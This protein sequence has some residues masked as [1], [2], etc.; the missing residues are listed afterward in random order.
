[1][2]GG[3]G[4]TTTSGVFTTAGNDAIVDWVLVEL[5]S[6]ADP[7]VIVATRAGLL[8]RDGD[9]VDVDGSSSLSFPLPNGNYQVAVRHRNHFG[10]MTA[11]AVALSNSPAVVDLRNTSTG[12]YG[13]EALKSIGAVAALWAGNVIVD[14][15]LKYTGTFNDRDPILTRIGGNVATNVVSGYYPEDANLDGDVKYTNA[16]ND[17]DIILVNIGGSVATNMRYEQLP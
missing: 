16:G 2:A 8:Q 9:I 5:R 14:G 13:T 17:R 3:G 10:C 4:E 1:M 7:T 15:S 6:T 12:T 11:D